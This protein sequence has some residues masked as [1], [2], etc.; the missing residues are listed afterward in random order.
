MFERSRGAAI[1]PCF[2]AAVQESLKLS[3]VT[4]DLAKPWKSDVSSFREEIQIKT[5]LE[6]LESELHSAFK[7]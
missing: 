5:E 3:N 7:G 4:M 2:L 6:A 1:V